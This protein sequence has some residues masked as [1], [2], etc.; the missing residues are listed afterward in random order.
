MK[1]A[2]G[3]LIMIGLL[4]AFIAPVAA[5]Q[6]TGNV[7]LRIGY[8]AFDPLDYDTFIDGKSAPALVSGWSEGWW[9]ADAVPGFPTIVL[10]CA[11]TPYL[12]F[13]SGVHSFGFVP[14]GESLDAA[15]LGPLEVAFEDDHVYSLAIT[16]EIADHSL[17]LLVVDETTEFVDA[18]PNADFMMTVVHDIAGAPLVDLRWNFKTISENLEYAGFATF[19]I[20]GSNHPGFIEVSATGDERTKL[21]NFATEPPRVGISAFEVLTGSYPG[22]AGEDY[23]WVLNW[24][25]SGALTGIDGGT[26]AVGDPVSG[27][28]ADVGNR[29]RYA[30]TLDSDSSLNFTVN[31]TGLATDAASTG[32]F[33][34]VVYIY[35][36]RGAL[37]FWNDEIAITGELRGD[38]DAGVSGID[39]V[40]GDYTIEVGGYNDYVTGPYQL[41][42][43]S[44]S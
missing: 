34:P 30:L 20:V 32:R 41:A 27:E 25:N 18:D 38:Y 43:E 36:T 31:A 11:V 22:A 29:V 26:V 14:K 1:R 40:A 28:I 7:R 39:L 44:A 12:N 35:D 2:L 24:G 16:G 4:L 13:S 42:V 9:L 23:F 5:Q 17:N 15:V 8:Y 33:D 19:S 3:L 10:C 21:F 37:L 6:E